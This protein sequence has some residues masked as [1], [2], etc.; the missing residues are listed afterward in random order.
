[1]RYLW[2]GLTKK[3]SVYIQIENSV[4]ETS[5]YIEVLEKFARF[6]ENKIKIFVPLSY[7]DKDWNF[8]RNMDIA[9]FNMKRQQAIWNIEAHFMF[10]NIILLHKNSKNYY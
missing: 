8:M 10:G 3:G 7:V 6:K 9:I 1:M 2:L 5:N 4:T